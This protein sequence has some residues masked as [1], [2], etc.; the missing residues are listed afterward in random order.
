MNG[1]S[2][3]KEIVRQLLAA[4]QPISASRFAKKFSV[5]RQIIVGD[6]AL[7][8]AAGA[9]INATARGYV[10]AQERHG[11]VKKIVCQHTPE[12]I[13][14]EFMTILAF[15]GKIID[16]V[17]EHPIY[18]E[19]TGGLHIGTEREAQEYIKMYQNSHAALLS[20]LT[21]G[22]HLHTIQCEDEAAFNAIT[23]DLAKK[24]ILYKE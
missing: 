23:Q 2:R 17:V 7:L 24:G 8:R 5:S 3:R 15:G 10:L 6:V 4:E 21:A 19:I 14:D 13:A 11:Y 22:I 18:G 9:A 12:Q 1:E 16:V 20:E